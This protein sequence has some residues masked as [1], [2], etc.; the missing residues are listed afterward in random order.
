MD[1]DLWKNDE[2]VLWDVTGGVPLYHSA[3]VVTAEL[4]PEG[5]VHVRQYM[6][7]GRSLYMMPAAGG[8]F[9]IL[10]LR[11]GHPGIYE[12][13]TPV[14]RVTNAQTRKW[15]DAG[16]RTELTMMEADIVG[17]VQLLEGEQW[18]E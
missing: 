16:R 12:N 14:I 5:K 10:R 13:G 4:G 2:L 8:T 18:N 17:D 7:A 3:H 9:E 11:A 6:P 1:L 15:I